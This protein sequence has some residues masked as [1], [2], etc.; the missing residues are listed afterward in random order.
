[1][2]IFISKNRVDLQ[3]KELIR[4]VLRDYGETAVSAN[5]STAYTVDLTVA[6]VF[7]ITMTG[8]CTFTFSNPPASGTGGGF[9]LI[10]TQDGTGSRTATWPASVKWA[11]GTAPTLTT[12]LTTGMDVLSFVTTDGGTTWL[13][14]L[15]GSDMS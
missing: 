14:F 10:L 3:D 11:G 6:N 15:A 7:D 2:A 13:G 12:T 4:P 9:T 8:N 1:M 5:S